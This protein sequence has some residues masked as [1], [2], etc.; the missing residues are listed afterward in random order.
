[1]N[2]FKNPLQSKYFPVLI[3]L[4]AGVMCTAVDHGAHR[5]VPI[6]VWSFFAYSAA[7]SADQPIS[8]PAFACYIA[9]AS[10]FIALAVMMVFVHAWLA[11]AFAAVIGAFPTSVLFTRH[12]KES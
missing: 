7:F 10:L 3:A 11:F 1:M 5:V 12:R 4:I 9:M 6:F 8:A 2:F